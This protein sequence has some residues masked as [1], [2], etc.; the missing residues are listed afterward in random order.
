MDDDGSINWRNVIGLIVGVLVGLAVI[1]GIITGVFILKKNVSRGQALQDAKNRVKIS[2]IE[3]RNQAQRVEIAKQQAE[4][5]L[6][7]A[8]GVR[9]AQDEIAKTLTPL[10]VQFEMVD[11]LKAIAASGKNNSVVFVPGGANG[12]PLVY[13]AANATKVGLPNTE[14]GK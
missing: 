9:E 14:G 5:R 12:I 13:D 2:T 10:Y 7:D 8:I 4:I 1:I 11:A 6:Q 3:I